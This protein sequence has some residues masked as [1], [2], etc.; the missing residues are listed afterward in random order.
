MGIE[1]LYPKKKLSKRHPDHKIYPYL[2]KNLD[3]DRPNMVWC[4][5]I[6]Y[7]RLKHGFVYLVAVLDWYSRKVLSWRLSNTLD[8]H[9]CIDALEEA[10]EK[11]E[12][13]DIFN[14]DQGSQFTSRDF[15]GKLE[16]NQIKVSMDG[17][18]RCLDNVVV[19]RFWR[20]LK[21][22]EVYLKDYKN[23]TECKNGINSYI[24]KYNS[25]RPH[26]SLD[27]ITPEMAY[28]KAA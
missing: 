23:M 16:K 1:A 5:D 22:D 24:E 9:F 17:K 28:K 2:V 6:T 20:T 3:I 21:Q 19:E 26:S 10:L 15:V 7:I 4:T 25:F 8:T 14:T 27:G 11:Y 12:K 18:G 13:P